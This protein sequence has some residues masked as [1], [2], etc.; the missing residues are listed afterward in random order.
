MITIYNAFQPTER[1]GQMKLRPIA[2][3]YCD[4]GRCEL[5]AREDKMANGDIATTYIIG[6]DV[7]RSEDGVSW[8]WGDYFATDQNGEEFVK[9]IK[10][11]RTL[12]AR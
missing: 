1:N 11:L 10:S 8:S 6:K 3:G 9:A 4:L 2:Y 5:F 12:C 7:H